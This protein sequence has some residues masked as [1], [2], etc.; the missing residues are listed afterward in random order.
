MKR[1]VLLMVG[2]FMALVV[3]APMVSAQSNGGAPWGR[4]GN[5]RSK[6]WRLPR[7]LRVP[8]QPRL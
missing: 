2:I 7:Q 1:I 6:P 3:A 5:D 8:L 4:L